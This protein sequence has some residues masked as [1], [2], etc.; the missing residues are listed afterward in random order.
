M[1][2]EFKRYLPLGRLTPLL[3][4]YGPPATRPK[5]PITALPLNLCNKSLLVLGNTQKQFQSHWVEIKK[6]KKIK[7]APVFFYSF[8]FYIIFFLAK[9]SKI[10]KLVLFVC[11]DFT[12]ESIDEENPHVTDNLV[13]GR[14]LPAL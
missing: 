13:S 6:K 11:I 14:P 8:F 7:K 5:D 10:Y 2:F 1:L 9:D 4:L 12:F 3:T